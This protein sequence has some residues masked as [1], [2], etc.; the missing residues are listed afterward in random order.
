[1]SYG[2]DYLREALQMEQDIHQNKKRL[3][4]SKLSEKIN[5]EN[6]E[7]ND[8]LRK[9]SDASYNLTDEEKRILKDNGYTLVHGGGSGEHGGIITSDGKAGIKRGSIPKDDKVDWHNKLK[10][11]PERDSVAPSYKM[12][13][14]SSGREK[15]PLR[16]AQQAY[17]MN[18]DIRDFKLAKSDFID[19]DTQIQMAKNDLRKAGLGKSD[20]DFRDYYNYK[21]ND[22][23]SNRDENKK[24]KDAILNKHN[25]QARES[26]ESIK[27]SLGSDFIIDFTGWASDIPNE[28]QFFKGLN[29]GGIPEM[30]SNPKEAKGFSS[31]DEAA[32]FAIEY[33]VAN[34][35]DLPAIYP[36]KYINQYRK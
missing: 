33:V 35:E 3:F 20:L 30:T 23:K 14:K 17:D 31:F 8:V 12:T 10:V 9:A 16:Y 4:E 26:I 15:L 19:N 22:A 34:G 7:I 27:E 28:S 24:R 21:L 13:K 6:D 25:V 32:E 11:K 1:M 18:K 2:S 36:R 5:H 29:E